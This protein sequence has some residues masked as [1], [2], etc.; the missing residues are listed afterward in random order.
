MSA[1]GHYIH[2]SK[3]GY[4]EHGTTRSGKF[5]DPSI[6]YRRQK[7][8]MQHKIRT[9]FGE[10]KGITKKKLQNIAEIIEGFKGDLTQVKKLPE[11][12]AIINNLNRTF[13]ETL[14]KGE[15][16]FETASFKGEDLKGVGRVSAHRT[17]ESKTLFLDL[18]EIVSKIEKLESIMES[19]LKKGNPSLNNI[20]DLKKK[21]ENLLNSSVKEINNKLK[22]EGIKLYKGRIVGNYKT[23]GKLRDELNGLIET[24]AP[25]APIIGLEGQLFEDAIAFAL[26]QGSNFAEEQID[27]FLEKTVQGANTTSVK[28]Y[29]QEKFIQPLSSNSF[30]EATM[31]LRS[32][33][34][35]A[36]TW[37]DIPLKISAKN[38]TFH[39]NKMIE[40][41]TGSPLLYMMQ[42]MDIVF[43]NHWINL[44]ALFPRG[45][46]KRKDIDDKMK[47]FLFYKSLT[48][49]TFGRDDNDLVNLFVVNDK[50]TGKVIVKNIKDIIEAAEK[51]IQTIKM[52]LNGKNIKDIPKLKNKWH[53]SG[54][55]ARIATILHQLH[56]LKVS[57]GFNAN[58]LL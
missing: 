33:V 3:K 9:R 55:E 6:S 56:E 16:D 7:K 39:N 57:A 45:N 10:K 8:I 53:E 18:K 25:Y 38:I 5:N 13:E 34:D 44:H 54:P 37:N 17:K 28:Q 35:I 14:R 50:I 2:F 23:I 26:K 12:T 47:L 27:T 21:Y 19:P 40:T 15:L 41:V 24:Y 31:P 20:A 22:N 46:A 32:K 30:L 51:N 1:I 42:D 29:N 36:I 43:V 48:G 52:Q 4:E 58:A 49:D 11:A